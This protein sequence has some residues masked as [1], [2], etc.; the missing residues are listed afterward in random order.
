MAE[1]RIFLFGQGGHAGVIRSFLPGHTKI[2]HVTK[3]G[4]SGAMSEEVFFREALGP[5]D[6]VYLGIGDNE[7]RRRLFLKLTERGFRLPPLVAPGATVVQGAKLGRAVVVCPGAVVMATASLGDNVI[8]NTLSS[9]DHDCV[10]GDHAQLT[11]GVILGGG[12]KI[13]AGSFLGLRAA[14]IPSVELGEN[15]V[16]MAG[17]LVTKSYPKAG[18]VLGGSPAYPARTAH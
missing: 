9:V 7:I 11:A 5:A 2:T 18:T 15:T 6:E 1:S 3:E 12:V 10:V 8:L 14:V 4:G 16:V 13:G 17:S